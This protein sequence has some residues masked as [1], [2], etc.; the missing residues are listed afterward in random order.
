MPSDATT[1]IFV[2]GMSGTGKSTV[3]D[4][5][6][7]KGW[8][9]IDTDFGNWMIL[10]DDGDLIWDEPRIEALLDSVPPSGRLAISGTVRNQTRFRDRFDA[11]ILLS[12]PL[13]TMLRRVAARDTNPYGGTEAQRE[14]IR[15][16]T[17][18]IL[19]LLRASADLELDTS[20]LDPERVA[21]AIERFVKDRRRS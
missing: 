1:I 21:E 15:H 4:V 6:A 9:S 19:P 16:Y 11:I 8:A 14:E 10:S 3:L 2:T 12:A 5:L 17:Q 7:R 13:D 20:T 18:T